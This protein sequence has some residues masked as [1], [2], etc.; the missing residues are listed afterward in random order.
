LRLHNEELDGVYSSPNVVQ[1]IR[2][3]VYAGPWWGNPRERDHLGDPGV[4]GKII[5]TL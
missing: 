1:V 5:L 2:S 4:G 3:R